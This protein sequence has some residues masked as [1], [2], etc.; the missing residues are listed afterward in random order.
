M[1]KVAVLGPKG[2]F[3]DSASYEYI[4]TLEEPVRQ[5]YYSTIDEAMAGIGTECDFAIVPVENTLDGFVDRTLDIL[6][7][8]NLHISDE[9]SIPVQFSL[10]ANVDS[11]EEIKTLFVQFK[12]NGQ[13]RKVIETLKGVSIITTESNVQSFDFV[14]RG[15]FGEAAII[16]KHML[17]R[18]DAS[19]SIENAT[20]SSN[21]VT[22]FVIVKPGEAKL[23]VRKDTKVR[24]SF[25]V[26]PQRDEPGILY[27]ILRA[28]YENS[29]NLVA[30]MSR[31]TKKDLGTY[32]FY[33]EIKADSADVETI[34]KTISDVKSRYGVK[35]LGFYSI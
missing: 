13:C 4:K 34:R 31:P 20:D 32:N 19:F 30:I 22:R 18:S 11:P 35:T 17:K 16:P 5:V 15:R 8:N 14:K 9:I 3:S 33:M 27:R 28:F 2:T 24:A 1:K 25:F 29:I 21:N 23:N 7:E 10:V 6:L 26:I 12:A